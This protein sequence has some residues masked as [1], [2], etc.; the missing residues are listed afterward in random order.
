MVRAFNKERRGIHEGDSSTTILYL[1]G[2]AGGGPQDPHHPRHA[3]PIVRLGRLLA[4]PGPVGDSDDKVI[5]VI[6]LIIIIII[7]IT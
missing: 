6:V 5:M 3:Q 1:A 7:I 2:S 4:G